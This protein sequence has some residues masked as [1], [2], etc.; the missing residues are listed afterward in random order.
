M[1]EADANVLAGR[2]SAQR[3]RTARSARLLGKGSDPLGQR[4]PVRTLAHRRIQ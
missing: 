1:E 2:I 4:P 3:W